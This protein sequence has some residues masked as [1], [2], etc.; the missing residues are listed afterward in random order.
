MFNFGRIEDF[1]E[2]SSDYSLMPD[3]DYPMRAVKIELKQNRAGN[4]HYFSVQFQITDGQYNNRIIFENFNVDH[5]NPEASRI[6]LE[7]VVKW[8]KATGCDQSGHLTEDVVYSLEGKTFIGSVKTESGKNG[9]ADKNVVKGF[10][11]VSP[12]VTGF[13]SQSKIAGVNQQAPQKQ[14][15][16][17]P[18]R[19]SSSWYDRDNPV[20][21]EEMSGGY[22]PQQ[23]Q[24]PQQ[25]SAKPWEVNQ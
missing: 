25:Q 17:K 7:D 16:K 4:G 21:A 10:S 11:P 9:Y 22:V 15:T 3:G 1:T 6:G 18:A 23:Q 24:V 5:P 20:S 14:P 2:P 12:S 19:T 13:N 8:L